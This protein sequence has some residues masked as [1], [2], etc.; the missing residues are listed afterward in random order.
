MKHLIYIG[1][2]TRILGVCNHRSKP[3]YVEIIRIATQISVVVR[4]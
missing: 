1:N 3:T 2:E 4:E